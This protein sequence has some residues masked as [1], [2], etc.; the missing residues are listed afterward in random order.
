[1]H[2]TLELSIINTDRW[3]VETERNTI[4]VGNFKPTFSR[5]DRT[6]RRKIKKET[7]YWNNAIDQLTLKETSIPGQ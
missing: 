1:M 7:D 6:T 3:K 2:S 5:I 4:I